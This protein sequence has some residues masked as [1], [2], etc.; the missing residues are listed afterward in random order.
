MGGHR[1]VA[2]GVHIVEHPCADQAASSENRLGGVC[3]RFSTI[4]T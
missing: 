1:G 4:A 3:Q 2:D